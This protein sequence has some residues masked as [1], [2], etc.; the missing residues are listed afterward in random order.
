M[1][2]HSNLIMMIKCTNKIILSSIKEDNIQQINILLR[3]D[4]NLQICFVLDQLNKIR[5]KA[6]FIQILLVGLFS[7]YNILCLFYSE[8]IE[9]NKIIYIHINS[10]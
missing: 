7:Y 8:F 1:Y 5:T 4:V 9:V 2:N 6:Y 3:C 10:K